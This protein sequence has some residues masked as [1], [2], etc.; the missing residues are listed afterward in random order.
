MI[1]KINI[2]I[3]ILQLHQLIPLVLEVQI[4]LHRHQIIRQRLQIQVD[5][6]K[7]KINLILYV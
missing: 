7:I 1:F 5:P 6:M 4:I 2:I 3:G